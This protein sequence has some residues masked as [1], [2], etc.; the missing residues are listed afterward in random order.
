M[1]VSKYTYNINQLKRSLNI[2]NDIYIIALATSKTT[3]KKQ[4]LRNRAAIWCF[5][6]RK[7]KGRFVLEVAIW[8]KGRASIWGGCPDN[9]WMIWDQRWTDRNAWSIEV[10]AKHEIKTNFAWWEHRAIEIKMAQDQT[11][12]SWNFNVFNSETISSCN[13][14]IHHEKMLSA[15]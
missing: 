3:E 14:L 9:Y 13:F 6:S 12:T 4:K 8:E 7:L 15:K 1:Y 5:S 2:E 10:C 11:R